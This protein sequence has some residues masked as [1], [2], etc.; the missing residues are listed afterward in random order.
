MVFLQFKTLKVLFGSKLGVFGS[1]LAKD[2][3]KVNTLHFKY[4]Y[5]S[6]KTFQ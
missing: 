4:V 3:K 1:F 5:I 6:E 2:V